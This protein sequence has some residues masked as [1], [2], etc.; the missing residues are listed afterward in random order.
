MERLR[1]RAHH[2]AAL[3]DQ[4]R[5]FAHTLRRLAEDFDDQAIQELAKRYLQ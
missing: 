4:Y 1:E 2:L 3:S 5:P